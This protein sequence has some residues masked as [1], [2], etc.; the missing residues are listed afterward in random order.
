[1]LFQISSEIVTG[2]RPPSKTSWVKMDLNLGLYDCS[3]T[4]Y[5]AKRQA[6]LALPAFFS[7]VY[8]HLIWSSIL[9]YGQRTVVHIY[10]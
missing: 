7:F 2:P 5:A 6:V 3:Q 9:T 4:L 1:M 8:Y 10:K